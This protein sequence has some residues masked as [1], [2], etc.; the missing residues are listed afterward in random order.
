MRQVLVWIGVIALAGVLIFSLDLTSEIQSEALNSPNS[1]LPELPQSPPPR[2]SNIN[3]S[4]FTPV[5]NHTSYTLSRELNVSDNETVIIDEQGQRKVNTSSQRLYA[6]TM[7]VDT[8]IFAF[9]NKTHSIQKK[10]TSNYTVYSVEASNQSSTVDTTTEQIEIYTQG[11]ETASENATSSNVTL[12][13]SNGTTSLSRILTDRDIPL[14]ARLTRGSYEATLRVDRQQRIRELTY[15]FQSNSDQLEIGYTESISVS[16]I[17]S[18]PVNK[19]DWVYDA[20]H[21]HKTY[22]CDFESTGVRTRAEYQNETVTT[23]VFSNPTFGNATTL[24]IQSSGKTVASINESSPQSETR[25]FD[26]QIKEFSILATNPACPPRSVQEI[27]IDTASEE[28]EV[29]NP[30]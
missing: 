5:S 13:E 14:V 10:T 1:S 28:I 8:D 15:S 30:E 24:L 25:R 18:T 16:N 20:I 26:D 23:V 17:D 11:Y 22:T 7:S 3:R 27:Y 6:E 21:A 19:P 2:E 9:Q 12:Y 29:S 4:R